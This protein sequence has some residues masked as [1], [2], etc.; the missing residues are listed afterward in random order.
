MISERLGVFLRLV[1]TRASELDTVEDMAL[2]ADI[3]T[4][5]KSVAT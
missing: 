1:V 2:G 3:N 5:D 4:P